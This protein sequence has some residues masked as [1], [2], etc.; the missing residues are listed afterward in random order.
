MSMRLQNEL[1]KRE[2][3]IMD[4]IY[5]KGSA[6]VKEVLGGL[7][8]PP[9]YS[10]VRAMLNILERK[11]FLRHKQEK[12][13]YVYIPVIPRKKA[14]LSAARQFLRTYFDGSVEEA[15]AALVDVGKDSLSGDEYARLSRLVKTMKKRVS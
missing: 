6:S 3:Q 14:M 1:S 2:R 8:D 4:V 12:L 5:R 7:P 13:R 11:E 15:V 9:S 10:A